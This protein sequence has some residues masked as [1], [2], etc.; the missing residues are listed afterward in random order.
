MLQKFLIALKEAIN[1]LSSDSFKISVKV[2]NDCTE[3]VISDHFE[4]ESD[5]LGVLKEEVL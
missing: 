1:E 2:G 3:F 5:H 4:G